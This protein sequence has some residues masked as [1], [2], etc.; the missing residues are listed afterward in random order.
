VTD[1]Y[2][3][4][5]MVDPK[6]KDRNDT[7]LKEEEKRTRLSSGKIQS[8][9][10]V[11]NKKLLNMFEEMRR[12]KGIRKLY[13]KLIKRKKVDKELKKAIKEFRRKNPGKVVVRD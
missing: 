8:P 4:E 6:Y 12:G 2:G 9:A 1:V 5:S 13:R 3:R 11:L 10:Q 7:T